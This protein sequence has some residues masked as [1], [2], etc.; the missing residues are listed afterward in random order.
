MK[1]VVRKVLLTC[2]LFVGVMSLSAQLSQHGLVLN[3][4]LGRVGSK[5]NQLGVRLDEIDYKVGLSLGYRS[6]FNK[7][8]FK[9]FHY[10]LDVNTGVK[11]ARPTKWNI[12]EWTDEDGNI[13]AATYGGSAGAAFHYTSIGFTANYSFFENLSVGLGVEPA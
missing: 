6:R 10:D 2:V 13:Y 9:T 7:P 8:A 12:E 5:S 4:G 1:D 11:G 3:G